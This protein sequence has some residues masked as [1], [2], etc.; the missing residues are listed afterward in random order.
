MV[1]KSTLAE[2]L[3]TNAGSPTGLEEEIRWRVNR[4]RFDSARENQTRGTSYT[5]IAATAPPLAPNQS[6]TLAAR[7]QSEDM[8]KN[9][10]FQ[11]ATVTG[12]AYYNPVTQPNPWDRMT[13]EGYIWNNAGENIAAGYSGAESVYV[14][15]WNS[16]GHRD[17]MYN[18]ALRE[19]GNGYY[20]WASSTYGRYYTMDLGS[21]GNN[22]FFT[23][24]FFQDANANGIYDSGEGVAGIAV[25]LMV[26]S[27]RQ[28][29]YGVS[30]S[31]G[32]FAVPSQ[33]IAPGTVV[34]VVLSNT[35]TTNITL[36]IPRDYASFTN[37]TLAAGQERIYGTFIQ[38][39]GTANVGFRSVTPAAASIVST[40]VAL[41]K[42]GQGFTLTWSS[43][44]GL[45]YQPQWSHDSKVW[46]NL[47]TSPQ[48]GTGGT[49]TFVDSAPAAD[50]RVY[51]LTILGQ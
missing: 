4:G 20:Y 8:A 30:S 35:A 45:Q 36:S 46:S 17:N 2:I 12:S 18:A 44:S 49:M 48:P 5:D 39:S 32:S 50:R 40:R 41:S 19:I 6:L 10:V 33:S 38:P 21:C 15:W 22:T 24:T 29:S 1:A 16:T 9:N 34:S 25:R 42:T 27:V 43:Q 47:V 13:A 37:Y 26:G 7:H 28:N 3:Y 11:H 31:S 23:D 14:G 51:R